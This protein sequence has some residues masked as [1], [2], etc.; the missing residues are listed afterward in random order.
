MTEH[1]SEQ[2]V[3]GERGRL[4]RHGE[5]SRWLEDRSDEELLALELSG[6]ARSVWSTTG[7]VELDGA[8]VFVKRVPVTAR[9]L[10]QPGATL[11]HFELPDFYH[12][13]VGSAGFGAFREAQALRSVTDWMAQGEAGRFPLLY[14]QRL[15]PGSAGPWRGGMSLD[16][17]VGY[18]AGSSA[19]ADMMRQRE[20]ATHE[21]WMFLEFVPHM[22]SDWL[23]DD[24]QGQVDTVIAQMAEATAVLRS[25]GMVHFDAHLANVMTDG[26]SIYLADFGLV[27]SADFDISRDERGFLA[28]HDHYDLGLA[29]AYLGIVL[30]MRVDREAEEVKDQVGRACGFEPGADRLKMITGLVRGVTNVADV[31]D[32]APQ[33]VATLQRYSDVHE[34][35]QGFISAL[36]T[37]PGKVARY[38]DAALVVRLRAA[39]TPLVD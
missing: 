31:V 15:L 34:Y 1:P 38:D 25:H 37:D 12:Y 16:D 26:V 3:R 2:T 33:F 29:I 13:G 4:A 36:Q 11:N 30:A 8:P 24:G 17:Y 27:C 39:G 18:W 10:T 9:E 19:V 35:M 14:H 6:G 5:L 23:M 28:R 7:A 22:V 20:A 21:L 32:L